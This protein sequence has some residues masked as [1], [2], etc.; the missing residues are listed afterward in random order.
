MNRTLHNVVRSMV[1]FK[2]VKLLFWEE[3]IVCESYIRNYFPSFVINNK[4]PYE[5]WYNRL[6]IVQHFIVFG[7]PCYDLFPK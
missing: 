3:E 4:F 1:F 5:L 6:P 7:S 2:K